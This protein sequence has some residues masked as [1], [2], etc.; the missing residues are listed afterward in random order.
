MSLFI[1][2]LLIL[3]VI[4]EYINFRLLRVWKTRS[5][6]VVEVLFFNVILLLAFATYTLVFYDVLILISVIIQ[7]ILVI[8]L[9]IDLIRLKL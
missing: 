8:G 3:I 1:I 7:I 2:V 6:E 4:T 5:Y 9:T